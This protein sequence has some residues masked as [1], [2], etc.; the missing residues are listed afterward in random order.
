MSDFRG[1]VRLDNGRILAKY[2][3]PDLF[4]V[5]VQLGRVAMFNVPDGSYTIQIEKDGVWEDMKK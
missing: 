3:A 5:V 2:S 1:R 4:D